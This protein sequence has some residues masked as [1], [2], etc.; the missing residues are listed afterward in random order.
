MSYD[1]LMV[2]QIM[3]HLSWNTTEQKPG[4]PIDACND[5]DGFQGDYAVFK[6]ISKGHIL[7]VFLYV[8]FEVIKL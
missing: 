8:G 4:K 1:G 6:T 2:K 3:V 7:Y 5:L